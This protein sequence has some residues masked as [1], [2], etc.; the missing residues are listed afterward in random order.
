MVLV[1]CAS[2][3][4]VAFYMDGGSKADGYVTVRSEIYNY[5]T[6]EVDPSSKE[7]VEAATKAC[8]KWGFNGTPEIVRDKHQEIDIPM[9]GMQWVQSY[10]C[11]EK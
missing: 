8:N 9:K 2:L 10:Q 5:F 11:S 6:T 7:A 3:K 1:G 4:P